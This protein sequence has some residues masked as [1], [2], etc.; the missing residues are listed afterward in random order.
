MNVVSPLLPETMNAAVARAYGGPNVIEIA[1]RPVPNPGPGQ[2]LLEVAA[3]GIDRGTR[4]LLYGY[5]LFLRLAFGLMRPKQP[6][7]GLDV[8]G[9]VVAVGE[10]VTRFVVGD[11]V[12]GVADGS[13]AEYAV[14]RED[15][16]VARPPELSVEQAAVVSVSGNTALVAV[17]EY[18]RVQPGQTVLITG[19]S[20]GVGCYAVQLA[21]AAGG[22][23]TGV[24][25]A[26]KAD[27]VRTLGA[28]RVLDY[29]V[30]DYANGSVQYDVILDI[31]GRMDIRKLLQSLAP[32]G[33]LVFIGVEG[34]GKLMGGMLRLIYGL[35]LSKFVGQNLRMLNAPEDHE[36]LQRVVSHIVAGDVTTTIGATYPLADARQ[37]L[38][39]LE[40]GKIRG[41]AVIRMR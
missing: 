4:H 14:A 1:K 7:I 9:R 15:K 34:G 21:V 39:D 5:P 29:R 10:R 31:G 16:L 11:E 23:V 20:G 35:L 12:M 19:A 2:L 36:H 38:H 18:A 33:M 32:D 25:S 3:A 17:E 26:A 24:S 37:A 13:V 40:D 30:D 27:F 28:A 22:E 41:K 6:V 8:A